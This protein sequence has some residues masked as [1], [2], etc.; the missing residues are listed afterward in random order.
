MMINNIVSVS[1]FEN[2]AVVARNE[3]FILQKMVEETLALF[4]DPVSA[5]ADIAV[6]IV[7]RCRS[8]LTITADKDM[9]GRVLVNIVSNA[10]RFAA[11]NST[12]SVEFSEKDDGCVAVSVSNTGSFIEESAREAI[13]NKFSSVQIAA[14]RSGFKNFGLGLTFAKMAVEAMNGR[15]WIACD[16]SV[17]STTFH[18]TVKNFTS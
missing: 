11:D 15:I 9:F 8:D 16:E 17:P 18:Y 3:P 10:L 2:G 13:F 4:L 5:D 6:S 7:Y 1:K 14:S 12:V